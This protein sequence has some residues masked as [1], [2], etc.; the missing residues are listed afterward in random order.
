MVKIQQKANSI[1]VKVMYPRVDGNNLIFRRLIEEEKLDFDIQKIVFDMDRVEY[2][3]SL[4]IAEFISL[5]RYF[6][7]S[8]DHPVEFEFIN[9]EPKINSIFQMV[10]IGKL[11]KVSLKEK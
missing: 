5:H 3:N 4:G 10:E 7:G 1:V 2:V 8:F 6:S 9:L 11:A